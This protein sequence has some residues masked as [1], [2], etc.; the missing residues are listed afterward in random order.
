[1]TLSAR[2]SAAVAAAP[3]AAATGT[4][5]GGKGKAKTA[6]P[7]MHKRTAALST[8]LATGLK[9]FKR[10]NSLKPSS[11]G[12]ASFAGRNNTANRLEGKTMSKTEKEIFN[13]FAYGM[14]FKTSEWTAL[15]ELEHQV[16]GIC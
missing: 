4:E 2:Q 15:G 13:A 14:P 9:K 10:Q 3:N 16:S 11:Y 8:E 5:S 7:P 1:L 6:G 12:G